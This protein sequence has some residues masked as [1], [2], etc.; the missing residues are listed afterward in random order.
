ME[1]T[2]R[3]T[4]L[5][6]RETSVGVFPI[7]TFRCS[8]FGHRRTKNI[9]KI[10]YFTAYERNWSDSDF[11]LGPPSRVATQKRSSKRD[12]TATTNPCSAWG[13]RT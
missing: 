6:T 3:P 8:G 4:S 7:L 12:Q 9:R 1:A 10:V 13:V 5:F 11:G 2:E